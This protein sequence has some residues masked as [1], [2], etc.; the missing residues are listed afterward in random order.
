M[1]QSPGDLEVARRHA[2]IKAVHL[3]PEEE[4]EACA[5]GIDLFKQL[6]WQ[7]ARLVENTSFKARNEP[8]VISG[9]KVEK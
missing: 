3:T 1:P 2:E 7:R 4:K 9:K 6:K 8:L 5:Y